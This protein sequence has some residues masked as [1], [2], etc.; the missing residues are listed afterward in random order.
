MFTLITLVLRLRAMTNQTA[1][2]VA[3]IVAA[4]DTAAVERFARAA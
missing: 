4:N 3:P 2:P 1:A